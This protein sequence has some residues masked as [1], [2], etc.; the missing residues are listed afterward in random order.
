MSI[1]T[2]SGYFVFVTNVL[3]V[4]SMPHNCQISVLIIYFPKQMLCLP[5]VSDIN[6]IGSVLLFTS[7]Y[8]GGKGA[9]SDCGQSL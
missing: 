3:N 5:L 7:S 9:I 8:F 1:L 4:T 6:G 2:V